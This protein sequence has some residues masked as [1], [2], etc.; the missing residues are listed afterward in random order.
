MAVTARKLVLSRPLTFFDL[1]TTGTDPASDR[2]VE[3]SV[4]RL[5]P[6]GS[7]ES[8]T[9]RLTPGRPIPAGATAVHGIRDDDVRDQPVFRQIARA[10]L[11][12]LGEGDLG[13][14]NV[15]R[16]DLP[17]LDRE[18]RDCGLD[19]GL[20]RRR[21]V[22]AMTIYHRLEPRHLSA[23]VRFYLGRDHAGAHGAEADVAATVEVLEAQIE[24]YPELPCSVDD[25]DG[26]C[27]PVPD[28]A[29]DRSGKFVWMEGE[30]VFAFGRHKGRPLREVA[31][32]QGDYLAWLITCDFPEDAKALVAGALEGDFPAEPLP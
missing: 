16:F 10:L 20:A 6:D 7:R 32:V 8:R 29:A 30:V 15:Q 13:G 26:W 12:F 21:V 5:S 24:R 25:L 9:R 31:Q 2:I 27:H 3:I 11:A 14:F 17:L 18:F 22:D 23:A 19:L 28:N 4:L 1:E